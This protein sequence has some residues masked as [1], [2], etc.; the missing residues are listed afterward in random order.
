[1]TR[2]TKSFQDLKKLQN[3]YCP[4]PNQCIGKLNFL[5]FDP[6]KMSKLQRFPDDSLIFVHSQ[7]SIDCSANIY[8]SPYCH[9]PA[10]T[11]IIRHIHTI[12]SPNIP[13]ILSCDTMPII[14]NELILFSDV[15]LYQNVSI[16]PKCKLIAHGCIIGYGSVLTKS[17]AE[18]YSIW[19]G[20]PATRIG[21]RRG[22]K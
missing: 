17:I 7:A 19:A 4:H 20:N 21:T 1:M 3:C 10:G 12:P 8:L 5:S 14:A 2:L 16:L 15:F 6:E 18:P 11:I 9:I 22:S 13:T